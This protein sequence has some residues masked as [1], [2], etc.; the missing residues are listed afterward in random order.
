MFLYQAE[1][2][3]Q[4]IF[5]QISTLQGHKLIM[6]ISVLATC[7]QNADKLYKFIR[8]WMNVW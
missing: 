3:K 6:C 7:Y 8:I 1:V 4:T 2:M 5:Q